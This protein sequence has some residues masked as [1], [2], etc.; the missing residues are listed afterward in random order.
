MHARAARPDDYDAFMRFWAELGLGQPPP[1]RDSWVEQLCPQ[2]LFLADGEHLAAYNLAFAFGARGDVRQVVVAPEYRRRGVGRALM[3]AVADKLRAR[4]CTEWRLEVRANNAPAIALYRS[5]G[6]QPHCDIH[7]VTLDRDACARFAATRSGAHR[8]VEVT[9]DDDRE[10]ERAL[11]LG[12]GQL[13]R[14]RAHRVGSP[15]R[16]IG[17]TALTQVRRDFAPTHGLLFPFRAPD[18]DVAAHLMADALPGPHEVCVIDPAIH[19]ALLGAGATPK[20][21]QVEYAGAL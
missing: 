6:M 16:R 19:A 15:L 7:I 21:H 20:E 1:P 9:P 18:P 4:G 2:T 5:V 13:A 3:A 17:T 10:L 14:W 11:D 12:A 8:S